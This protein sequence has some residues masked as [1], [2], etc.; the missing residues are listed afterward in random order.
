M[1]Y[2]TR[3]V[4]PETAAHR[5]YFDEM[6]VCSGCR[7]AEE[8]DEIDWEARENILKE[9]LQ[10]HKGKSSGPYDCIVPV[11]GG[12]DS[13]FQ[14]HMIKEVYG[15]NPL[16]VTFNHQYNT[17]LG[18]DNLANL[19]K[20]LKVDNLRFT[21]NPEVIRKLAIM[22]M[23]KMGDF[24]WHCHT[25]I[26]TYPVQIAVKFN[27]PLIIWGEVGSLDFYGMYSLYD[28]VE[29]TRKQRVEHGMRGFDCQDMVSEEYGITERDLHWAVYPTDEELERVG[30][31]GLYL[32][33]YLKWNAKRHTE[34]MIEKYGFQTAIEPRTYNPYENVE[35][36]HC[37]GAHDYLK[38]LKWG[39]GRA[40]D[41]AAQ[42]IRLGRITR[43]QGIDY[44]AQYDHVR[45]SDMDTILTYLQ[46]TEE[47]FLACVDSMRD[48][49]AWKKD[50]NG[51][52]QL[53][54]HVKNHKADTHVEEVRL[55]LKKD[56]NMNFKVTFP[57]NKFC[58]G[59]CLM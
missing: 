16:L 1:K 3:C 45:P 53:Q 26:Y 59:H 15:L 56:E 49:R 50:E 29:M 32:G 42:D 55:P 43:E 46:M 13:H 51:V 24:C 33:N 5:M 44:V 35:C 21:P 37:G 30:V 52:W 41:H 34:L 31:R 22:S 12:K 19:I 10:E 40:T 39:Y 14:V 47:E 54:D 2:C 7:T 27:I 17:R 25:G 23:R 48:E 36:H 18:L 6:G 4:Y 28:L 38:Y 58:G 11:S 57:G 20:K 8:K 9:I